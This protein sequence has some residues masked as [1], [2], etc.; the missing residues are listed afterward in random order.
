[1]V[2][3]NESLLTELKVSHHNFTFIGKARVN[4]DSFKGAS[5]KEGKT[6][7]H[8]N[9]NFGVETTAGNIVYPRIWG[10]YKLDNPI[11]MVQSKQKG[12]RITIPY[13]HRNKKELLKNVADYS[14]MTA[15]IEQE[16]NGRVIYHKFIDSIDFE[17][18]LS[19]HLK[20]GMDIKVIGSVDYSPGKEEGQV[21]TNYDI[22]GVYLNREYE[23][24]GKTFPKQEPRATLYQAYLADDSTLEKGWEKQF[25]KDG[26]IAIQLYVP[27]YLSQIRN[28]QGTFVNWKKTSPVVQTVTFKDTMAKDVDSAIKF[29]GGLLKVKS[30]VV[31]EIS[32]YVD[33]VDGYQEQEMKE[34]GVSD[35]MKYL[36]DMGI[37]T[38]DEIESQ[39]TVRKTRVR[40]NVYRTVS[41]T[42]GEDGSPV[43]ES[44]DKYEEGVLVMP[45]FDD[46]DEE[47]NTSFNDDEEESFEEPDTEIPTEVD[48]DGLFN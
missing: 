3:K 9:S 44:F 28:E 38:E 25:K 41:V 35:E 40:E 13:E 5:N 27:Q 4:D 24:D 36:I 31:R 11:L 48:F 34:Y 39:M 30:G 22:S 17:N 37:I 45:S 15:G 14:F 23:K 20:D 10:G 2:K 32:M 18:Y 46:G 43:I 42:K 12:E 33:I 8:V 7:Y 19:E 1:M 21:Y 47:D 29:L 6:W 16:E 26:E